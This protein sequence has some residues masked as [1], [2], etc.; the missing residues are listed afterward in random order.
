M[1]V[2]LVLIDKKLSMIYLDANEE[3]KKAYNDYSELYELYTEYEKYIEKNEGCLI[4]SNK[5]KENLKNVK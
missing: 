1:S 2:L 5:I 3:K 4:N